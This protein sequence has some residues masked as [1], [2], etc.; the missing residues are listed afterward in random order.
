MCCFPVT[1]RHLPEVCVAPPSLTDTYLE[2]VLLPVTYIC[3]P[4]GCVAPVT[5]STPT[6]TL[7]TFTVLGIGSL[8]TKI[9]TAQTQITAEQ[10]QITTV[11][12]KN[13]VEV[14]II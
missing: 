13:N 4:G 10:T 14:Y 5:W 3:L 2:D 7:N 12:T 9:A 11:L 8:S 1:Y 6:F